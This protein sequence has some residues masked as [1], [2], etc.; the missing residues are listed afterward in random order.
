MKPAGIQA[1]ALVL[2]CLMVQAPLAAQVKPGLRIVVV[3]GEGAINNIQL[4]SGREPVVE[5]R[6]ENDK[7]VPGAK[8]TFTLPERGPG[9]TFFGASRNL[10]IPTNEQGRAAA[11]GFRPNLYEGR[12]QIQ[13]SA[14]AGEKTATAVIAQ[15]NALPTGGVNRVNASGKRFPTKA[16]VAL[17][18]IGA[19]VGIIA[20]TRGDEDTVAATVTPGTSITPGVVAVGQP[21]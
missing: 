4:G 12:F 14:A 16:V 13:V 11:T 9:G 5:V 8:V 3:D 6:D 21:R 10:T 15:S 17:V 7:P 2:S 20:G 19:V 18:V 1:L